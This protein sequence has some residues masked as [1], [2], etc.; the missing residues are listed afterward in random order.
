MDLNPF[1][2]FLFISII[3]HIGVQLL[4]ISGQWEYLLMD[5]QVFDSLLFFFL[6]K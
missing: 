6:E 2:V 4:P 3:I 1:D 5:S